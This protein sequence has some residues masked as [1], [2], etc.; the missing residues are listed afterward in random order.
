MV[1]QNSA[2]EFSAFSQLLEFI[3]V[4]SHRLD[5]WNDG[6]TSAGEEER[7]RSLQWDKQSGWVHLLI[8]DKNLNLTS[9]SSSEVTLEPVMESC[10]WSILYYP[11]FTLAYKLFSQFKEKVNTHFIKRHTKTTHFVMLRIWSKLKNPFKCY[12][13][14]YEDA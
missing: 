8:T 1:P 10:P 11:N 6:V 14:N 9:V 4:F 7:S 2:N 13:Y 3:L 5:L 12:L